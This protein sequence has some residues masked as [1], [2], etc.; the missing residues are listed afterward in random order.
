MATNTYIMNKRM[1]GMTVVTVDP[2]ASLKGKS[3]AK[4][5]AALIGPRRL[6]L[7]NREDLHD[8]SIPETQR[9][10]LSVNRGQFF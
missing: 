9:I 6:A 10:Y 8:F 3:L 1:T 2:A 5:I 4:W 7:K